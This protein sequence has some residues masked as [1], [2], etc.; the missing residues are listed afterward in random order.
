MVATPTGLRRLFT[1]RQSVLGG[2]LAFTGLG[3]VAAGYM[4]T[5]ALGVGPAGTLVTTG[6]LEERDRLLVADF[7]DRT[8]DPDLG[9]SVTEA[10]RI[11][12]SQS[13]VVRVVEAAEVSDVLRRMSRDLGRPLDAELAREVAEREGLKAIVTGDIGRLGSGY[14]VS[15][16][17]VATADG[18][19]LVALRETAD[20]AAGIIGAVDRLSSKLRERIGESLRTVRST[21]PLGRV[22]T[23]SLAALRKYSQGL[24]ADQQ[25]E[26]ERAALLFDEAIA[27]DT[28]FAMAYRALAA[29][30]GSVG[31][32]IP[33]VVAAATRAYEFRRNL[34]SLERYLTEAEYYTRVE[35]DR[36]RAAAAYRSA[37]EVEPDDIDALSGLAAIGIAN[38]RWPE[39]ESL[40]VRAIPLTSRWEP[41][42]YAARSQMAQGQ[43]VEARAP[44]D[45]FD[46]K[47]PGSPDVLS[48]RVRI[49]AT[50]RDYDSAEAYTGALE[51]LTDDPFWQ[52]SAAF[53]RSNIHWVRG[54][55]DAAARALERERVA[56]AG[57]NDARG[58]LDA[59]LELAYIELRMRERT[60]Q[61]V[62][63]VD[64]A[65]TR[66][67][68]D[69]IPPV[70]RPYT[71][72]VTFYADAGTVDRA[73]RL[74]DEYN[75]LIPE[76]A[77]RFNASRHGAAAAIARAEGRLREAI[78]GYRAW[79][80][81][82]GQCVI[83]GLFELA[84]TYDRTGNA[85]SAVTIFERAVAAPALEKIHQEYRDLAKAYK[86][87]GELYEERGEHQA[88]VE[89]Y[90]KF[91]EV[92]KDADPEL[93]PVVADVRA[94]IA[95]LVGE[96]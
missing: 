74:L 22:S 85:D 17:L 8:G 58:Y 65:L 3:V 34:P 72:L 20:D 42:I 57:R 35:F 54:E 30:L 15:A 29:V 4:T 39:A 44:I 83:C 56:N 27:E 50:L 51:Q 26:I 33:R 55:L 13:P 40:A 88:A 78:D 82:S 75:R 11:D 46:Q 67:P 69:S 49:V 36:S 86:R 68:L 61:A 12:L 41:H 16:R 96:R 24:R 70:G 63:I 38:R 93:Q 18:S 77:K 43:V 81:E 52:T 60:A 87:L 10:L 32:E 1:W 84:A 21:P 45:L 53:F 79:Y 19:V 37:L 89:Y 76:S 73:K 7:E 80:E 59:T 14:V 90:G 66:F 2:G 25:G 48:L 23:S 31:A 94:R 91:V 92:W 64:E 62:R 71:S 47:V 5:R 95:Q 9:T 6:V 28:T